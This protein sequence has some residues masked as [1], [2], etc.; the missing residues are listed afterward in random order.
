[1]RFFSPCRR[2]HHYISC[3]L[4]NVWLK[5]G[6]TVKD[7]SYGRSVSVTDAD[8]L[9]KLLALGLVTKAGRL[10]GRELRYLRS[11]LELSQQGLARMVGVTEQALSLWERTGKVPKS[12]DALVRMIA[13]EKLEG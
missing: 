12:G 4:N 10:S 1:M 6:Y 2:M 5:N 13:V 11:M 8:E 3:G 7:T 9:H